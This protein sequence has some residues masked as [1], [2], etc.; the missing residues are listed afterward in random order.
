MEQFFA[1]WKERAEE[2]SRMWR[3][4]EKEIISERAELEMQRRFDQTISDLID[5][6]TVETEKMADKIGSLGEE[7]SRQWPDAFH[8]AYTMKEKS[9]LL[10]R[11]YKANVEKAKGSG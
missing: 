6:L 5:E 8:L 4:R 9:A 7:V 2:L 11:A 1:G 3:Q 10:K